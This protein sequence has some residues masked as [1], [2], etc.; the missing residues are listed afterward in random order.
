MESVTTE[1]GRSSSSANS[2]EANT[3]WRILGGK[4]PKS[5]VVFFTQVILIY[6]V[7]ITSLVN[8]S[9]GSKDQLWVLLLTSCLGYLMPN[10]SLKRFSRNG[11]YVHD[12][13]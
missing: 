2:T 1:N 7:V 12:T 4:F 8:I 3:R 6:V 5:E 11:E 10:P 13:T 9:L